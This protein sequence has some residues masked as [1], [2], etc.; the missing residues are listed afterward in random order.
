MKSTIFT[1]KHGSMIVCAVTLLFAALISCGSGTDTPALSSETGDPSIKLMTVSEQSR[2][3]TIEVLGQIVYYEKV[4]VS[5]KVTGRLTRL[6]VS[7][8]D[9]VSRGSLIAEIERLPHELNLKE[10]MAELEI[11]QKNFELSKAKYE[12]AI[13]SIEIRFKQ[14]DKAK[15]EVLDKKVTWQNIKRILDNK[16]V[17]YQAGGI[18]KTDFESYKAQHTTAHTQYINA[19]AD[20][21][22]QE[23]GFRDSDI[24]AEGLT[25]PK[26]A[27]MK[28]R[29]L[30]RINT[31]IEKAELEAARSRITQVQKSIESTK[32]MLGETYIRSPLNGLV[33]A[34]SMEAGEMVK[35]DSVIATL[36]TISQVYLSMNVSEKDTKNIRTGQKVHFTV[37]A[38]E[39]VNFSGRVARST[40]VLDMKTRTLEVKAIV[41]NPGNKL[42]PGMF[43]RA[44]IITGTAADCITVPLGAL[45]TRD[46]EKGELFLVKKGLAFRQPVVLGREYSDE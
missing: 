26:T 36:I 46:G 20:L 5:S 37:D 40:P 27:A 16:K 19:K 21:A 1:G 10:Q 6:L 17:L 41:A 25:V 30:Q 11:A 12:N 38:F 2:E 8:G 31:K 15:A 7:E 43:A 3:E 35:A 29:M 13:K 44:K 45:L 14:I 42:L 24:R 32:I 34:K 28:V 23:V 18:S 9:R 4:N 39:G 33:A 22:I